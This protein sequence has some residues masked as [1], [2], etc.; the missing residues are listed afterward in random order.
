MSDHHDPNV[1]NTM[2]PAPSIPRQRR[3]DEGMALPLVLIMTSV[4][5]LTVIALATFAT[6][7]LKFGRVSEDRVAR[8]TAADAGLRYAID[9]LKL[10]N[11]GCILDTQKAVLPGVDTD[12]NSTGAEVSCILN[13]SGYESIQAFAVALTGEGLPATS[14]LLDTRGG[15]ND[16]VFGGPVYMERI[17]AAAFQDLEKVVKVEDGP[18]LYHDTSAM[19][20]CA[21]VPASTLPEKLV[22]EPNLI[23]GPICITRNWK[24]MFKSPVA[25]NLTGLPVRNGSVALPLP[26]GSYQDIGGCRVFEPGRYTTPPVVVDKKVYFK[27]GDYVF[28]FPLTNRV[29]E[30][31][32]TTVT[33]GRINPLTATAN[34]K[35]NP[36]CDMA[37]AND[38]APADQHGATFYMAGPSQIQIL[39]QGSLEIHA[40][41]QNVTTFVA[42]Q[43]LCQPNGTWC[44]PSGGGG[45]SPPK[46]ST[47]TVGSG[48]SIMFTDSGNNKELVSHAL[49]YAPQSQFEFGNTTNT[50]TQQMLGGM[51]L[52]RLILQSSTSATNFQISVPI[53]PITA[54]ITLTSTAT[55]VTDTSIQAVVEYRPYEPDIDERVRVNSWRVCET[56][57]CSDP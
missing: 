54:R 41:V 13:T 16:K 43:A 7:S 21:S 15:S 49:L 52:S 39:V 45:F 23:F 14:G 55:K 8:L 35:P 19:V 40:R 57:D 27:T 36:D 4:I 26:L 29:F 50:A 31:R 42:I 1:S 46:F 6:T 17:N 11:A 53:S 20:P 30:V 3:A 2:T 12:F 44:R 24:Q 32:K 18:L 37:Q 33:A 38:P 48:N 47:V 51:V 5:A 34:V 25:P 9:Q 28:D 56:V 22:F 10:R